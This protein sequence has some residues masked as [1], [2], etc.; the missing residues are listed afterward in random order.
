MFTRARLLELPLLFI[1]NLFDVI[2]LTSSEG[3]K[4]APLDSSFLDCQLLT[5]NGVIYILYSAL[6]QSGKA[7][8]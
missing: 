3:C 1:W 5:Q 4:V 6:A 7:Y 8:M 2:G